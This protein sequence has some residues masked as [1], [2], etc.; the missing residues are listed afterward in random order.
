MNKLI[1]ILIA[2]LALTACNDPAI[3]C[4]EPDAGM[5]AD[6]S[7]D[8]A[9]PTTVTTYVHGTERVLRKDLEDF[10]TSVGGT[11]LEISEAN[12]WQRAYVAGILARNAY[13]ETHNDDNVTIWL[14]GQVDII[15]DGLEDDWVLTFRWQGGSFLVFGVLDSPGATYTALPVC[16]VVTTTP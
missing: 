16:E 10:C 8:T 11:P 1:A 13:L 9:T 2:S 6:A 15:G 3:M 12:E 4:P 14:D 7:P 5:E